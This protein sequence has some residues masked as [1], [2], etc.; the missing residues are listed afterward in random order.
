MRGSCGAS[1]AQGSNN[2]RLCYIY[3]VEQGAPVR[4][5]T[6][7]FNCKIFGRGSHKRE[8]TVTYHGAT[9][10]NLTQVPDDHRCS[11][12]WYSSLPLHSAA[13]IDAAGRG[14]SCRA[15]CLLSLWSNLLFT[16]PLTHVL[17]PCSL[18]VWR[19]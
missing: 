17:V 14:P 19:G 4:R 13:L 16:P 3:P 1:I 6:A 12:V 11:P 15:Y 18:Y 10:D 9:L 7:S 2:F 8:Y 5:L